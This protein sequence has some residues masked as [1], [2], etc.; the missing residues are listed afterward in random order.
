M[1][2]GGPEKGGLEGEQMGERKEVKWG[3][4]RTKMG[5]NGPSGSVW[6]IFSIHSFWAQSASV[7]PVGEFGGKNV[8]SAFRTL[9]AGRGV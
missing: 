9:L 8:K 4:K 5:R 7:G 6:T 2:S 1:F 3:V